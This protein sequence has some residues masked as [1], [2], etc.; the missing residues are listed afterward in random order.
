MIPKGLR[1]VS[2]EEKGI[3]RKKKGRGFIYLD[4]DDCKVEDHKILNRIDEL[5]IPPNWER[6]WI[7]EDPTGHL[8][9]TGYDEKGRKQYLYHEDFIEY[10][11]KEKY[12]KI[13]EFGRLL[14]TIRGKV[15]RDMK[16]EGWPK[17]KVIALI[18]KIMDEFHFRIGSDHYRNE[19][20][21][22][23]I[24][25]LRRKHLTK[26]KG[27]IEFEY[28]GKSGRYRKIS[29]T[30][31]K[32]KKL[33][34]ETSE[35]PGYEIFRYIDEEGKSRRIQSQDVNEYIQEIANEDFTAKHF[36]TWGGTV[37]AVE[38][39]E[40]AKKE[41]KEN[42]RKKLE[43]AVV[44]RVAERLGNTVSTCREYYIHPDVLETVV[45]DKEV[46]VRDDEYADIKYSHLLK[47]TEK[48]V[49]KMIET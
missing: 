31:P 39:K 46:T 41:I 17:E 12:D 5:V 37:A 1:Y 43:T 29:I 38:E 22:Y 32:V 18:I 19:N 27:K 34:R 45:E 36:R 13:Y 25:T 30:N 49:L 9:A 8:Q 4:C 15:Q 26:K 21:T 35:L 3:L 20:E 23:G 11:Q 48:K 24:T 28:K 10:R 7:C 42:P 2:G 33:I 44:R 6:V 40:E 16:K 47:Q 14:P